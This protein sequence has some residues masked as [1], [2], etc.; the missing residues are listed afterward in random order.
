MAMIRLIP[1]GIIKITD[2]SLFTE[3]SS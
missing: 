1:T 3:V 2:V